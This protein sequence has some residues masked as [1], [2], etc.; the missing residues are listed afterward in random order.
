LLDARANGFQPGTE[1]APRHL[2]GI[3]G[4]R[5]AVIEI[6][7]RHG[8]TDVRDV[9]VDERYQVDPGRQQDTARGVQA[10]LDPK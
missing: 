7:I 2:F 1:P 4:G 5:T 8:V 10:V 6:A 9:A 3:P